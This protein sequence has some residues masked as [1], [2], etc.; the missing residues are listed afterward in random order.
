M[1]RTTRVLSLVAMAGIAVAV[2]A[3]SPA[4]SPQPAAS[5]K[6]QEQCPREGDKPCGMGEARGCSGMTHE[7]HA[8]QGHHGGMMQG[9]MAAMSS[10][11][12]VKHGM[13]GM[14]GKDASAAADGCPVHQA[15][16]KHQH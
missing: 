14:H 9:H 7:G 10:S 2:F 13:G 12:G 3:Q 8:I 1:K 11:M 6:A 15:D 4:M 16:G 5:P